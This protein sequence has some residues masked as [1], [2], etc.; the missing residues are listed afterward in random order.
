MQNKN[1]Y[2]LVLSAIPLFFC[3]CSFF[4]GETASLVLDM[5]TAFVSRTREAATSANY[6]DVEGRGLYI[7]VSLSGDYEDLL[8]QKV[9]A[10]YDLAFEKVPV[11][12][13]VSATAKIYYLKDG[14]E[15]DFCKGSSGEIKVSRGKNTLNLVLSQVQDSQMT[16]IYVKE[17]AAAGGTG[18]LTSPLPSISNALGLV[19][20]S[21]KDYTIVVSG[22]IW[23]GV[24]ISNIQAK[25]LSITGLN[26]G[27]SDVIDGGFSESS[28]G[29]V[30]RVLT[31][32]PVTFENIR[33]TGGYKSSDPNGDF[34]GGLF[35][36]E[37]AE[38]T[39]D[40]ACT[41]TGNFAF[42]GGGVYVN[43]DCTLI[44]KDGAFIR[45][46]KSSSSGGG[47]C[48]YSNSDTSF[49]TIK[50]YGGSVS[51]NLCNLD[52]S[53]GYCGGISLQGK[54]FMYGGQISGNRAIQGGGGITSNGRDDFYSVIEL[55][56]GL[57]SGNRTQGSGG[58]I[59]LSDN[60]TFKMYGGSIT[61]NEA[62]NYGGAIFLD[63][64]V[65]ADIYGGS[66]ENNS[67]STGSQ[68]YI[69]DEYSCELV[70]KL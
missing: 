42:Q 18:A 23:E 33:I 17:N 19:V 45:G 52:S 44:I 37:G 4:T 29:T 56:D 6:T 49:S 61:G 65:D 57:I 1:I 47:I 31:Q 9:Q 32:V 68:I 55:Y 59:S 15:Y 12:S 63:K 51:D 62:G 13:Q 39:L 7:S 54:L 26:S 38:V 43:A 40:S 24:E 8:T 22:T 20:D 64:N 3:A 66:I 60:V 14:K 21:S 58:G 36:G 16:F 46:N 35:L 41:I 2:M 25:S 10:G 27:A 69:N 70:N 50:M 30:I 67:D 28:E 5:D 34:G 53:M 48:T 11:G